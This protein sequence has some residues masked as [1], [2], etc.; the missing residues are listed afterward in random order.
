MNFCGHTVTLTSALVLHLRI[1]LQR[2]VTTK[3]SHSHFWQTW[4][5]MA[6]LNWL[7]PWSTTQTTTRW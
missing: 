1:L 3:Q 6:R 2:T 5:W 4:N 7:L